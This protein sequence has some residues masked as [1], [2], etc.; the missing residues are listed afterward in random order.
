MIFL[1]L[2][3]FYSFL[4]YFISRFRVSAL[5]RAA[6]SGATAESFMNYTRASLCVLSVV[7]VMMALHRSVCF[8]WG[9]W[10]FMIC[11]MCW[12]CVKLISDMVS[13]RLP[14]YCTVICFCTTQACLLIMYVIYSHWFRF[15]NS[16]T[17]S[18][19]LTWH[20]SRLVNK[21]P[22]CIY[23][24]IHYVRVDHC[25]RVDW[26]GCTD[27]AIYVMRVNSLLTWLYWY[28]IS[29]IVYVIVY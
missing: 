2:F 9:N 19:L 27:D 17:V 20:V 1:L 28:I 5:D 3:W 7:P 18:P 6:K 26:V 8:W 13:L 22:L 29:Y 11:Q 16:I 4:S 10:L 12:V 21:L 23:A 25:L 14:V 24:T 15:C